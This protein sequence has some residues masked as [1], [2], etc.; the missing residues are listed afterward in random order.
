MDDLVEDVHLWPLLLSLVR[1]HISSDL[2]QY[3]CSYHKAIQ[4]VQAKLHNKGLTAFDKNI[5]DSANQYS[6]H[7]LSVQV[8]IEATLE[9]LGSLLNRLK[10]LVLWAGIRT[11]VLNTALHIIWNISK[12]DAKETVDGLWAQGILKKEVRI[13]LHDN[14]LQCIEV[15]AHIAEYILGCMDSNEIVSLSPVV[16]SRLEAKIIKE[17]QQ[18]S[19]LQNPSSL[20]A[21]EYLK[22][23]L[24]EIE[25]VWLP[26]YYRA[27]NMHIFTDPHVVIVK[28]QEI[29][30]DTLCTKDW[31]NKFIPLLADYKI[32]LKVSNKM[33]KK[34][35]QT[36]HER[37]H[38]QLIQNIENIVKHLPLCNTIHKAVDL[39]NEIKPFHDGEILQHIIIVSEELQMMTPDYHDITTWVLPHLKLYNSILKRIS[40]SLQKNSLDAEYHYFM[41]GKIDI[42][43][44]LLKTNRLIKL[45][46][47]APHYVAQVHRQL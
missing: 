45:Q 46:K 26:F 21:S 15:E 39:L 25:N 33:Y 41:S 42:D 6:S 24:S 2:K 19:M 9:L 16:D 32:A 22:Y 27:V 14:E 43:I 36:V 37:N 28:L 47:I 3:R 12:Q 20:S 38:D 8:C 17:Y 35:N 11:S 31:S 23:K 13:S 40:S 10:S 29:L 18:S 44:E 30:K 7:T 34:L 1:A 5:V 4:N